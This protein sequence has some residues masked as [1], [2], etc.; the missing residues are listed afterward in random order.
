MRKSAYS[1]SSFWQNPPKNEPWREPVDDILDALI[2]C[3][4]LMEQVDYL[5]Q[6]GNSDSEHDKQAGEQLLGS[7]LSLRDRLDAGFCEMQRRLG[8][9]WSSSS[10]P[11][12]WS[13]LDPSIP[14]YLFPDAIEYPSLTCADSHLLY[15]TTFILLYPLID[16]LLQFL[17]R[18]HRDVSFTLFSVPSSAPE[19]GSPGAWNTD[20]PDD[21]LAV[22]DHYANHI[23]RSAKY[24]VQ[25][26]TKAMGAQLLLAPFSQATQFYHSQAAIDKHRWC[27]AVFMLFPQLGFGI[28]PFL[29]DMIWPRYEASTP[30]KLPSPEVEAG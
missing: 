13:T 27:Q 20:L 14:Q 9:P 17:E 10:Q 16:Q 18:S 28:A 7:F 2:E 24:L 30:K 6:H 29:K 3:S 4:A 22:A 25:P 23:C 21:L 12:F 11:P 15:W 8:T 1:Y 19:D 26:E 5:L